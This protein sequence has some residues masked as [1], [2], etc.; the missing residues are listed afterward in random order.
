MINSYTAIAIMPVSENLTNMQML[1]DFEH[2]YT[3]FQK[4]VTVDSQ[5]GCSFALA[6]CATDPEEG[7]SV[8]AM[9]MTHPFQEKAFDDHAFCGTASALGLTIGYIEED[10]DDKLMGQ[11]VNTAAAI[12]HHAAD[13][14]AEANMRFIAT[15]NTLF[16]DWSEELQP[17]VPKFTEE[18]VAA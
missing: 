3:E 10:P 8:Q 16:P 6:W 13:G 18:P 17:R 1:D 14:C 4:A 9:V 5:R 11:W 12:L 7:P 15:E 2:R